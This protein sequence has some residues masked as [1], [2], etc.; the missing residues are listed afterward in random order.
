[1]HGVCRVSYS[2]NL[3]IRVL[4]HLLVMDN[5]NN[6]LHNLQNHFAQPFAQALCN[7]SQKTHQ[8]Y[9]ALRGDANQRSQ[10]HKERVDET[11]V[12]VVTL[13]KRR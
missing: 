4:S 11:L 6:L 12:H 2:N 10:D 5:F 3:A 9:E 1:M 13:K 8:V 7:V